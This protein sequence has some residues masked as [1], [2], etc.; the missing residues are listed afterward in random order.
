MCKT[1]T[2]EVHAVFKFFYFLFSIRLAPVVSAL[3]FCH[4]LSLP[5]VAAK[6]VSLIS[7]H[8][9]SLQLRGITD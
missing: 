6:F 2:S 1:A 3:I 8:R 9:L 4:S 7:C 5:V